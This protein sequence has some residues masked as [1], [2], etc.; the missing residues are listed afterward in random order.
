LPACWAERQTL[1]IVAAQWRG[2]EHMV[3]DIRTGQVL[4]VEVLAPGVGWP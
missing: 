2:F 4:S 3:S 1:F